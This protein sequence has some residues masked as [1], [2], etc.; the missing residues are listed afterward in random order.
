[1][2]RALLVLLVLTAWAA[3]AHAQTPATPTS[4]LTFAIDQ[5][6][7]D[8][9]AVTST[10]AR[11]A[12]TAATEPTVWVTNKG[13]APAC[14]ALGTASVTAVATNGNVCGG[15]NLAAGASP[16]WVPAGVTRAFG[17]GAAVDVAGVTLSGT[18]S[19]ILNE[20]FLYPTIVTTP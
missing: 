9:L 18:T 10:S 16:T 11:V 15:T 12:M 8:T 17:I 1:M 7:T 13:V 20:G 4:T 5:K 19:L 3:L 2:V 6:G 14:V